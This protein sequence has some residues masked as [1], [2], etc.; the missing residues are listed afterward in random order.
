MLG[1]E[2]GAGLGVLRLE[3]GEPVLQLFGQRVL[4]EAGVVAGSRLAVDGF[5]LRAVG[6]S[7]GEL[8]VQ[9]AQPLGEDV[10]ALVNGHQVVA[11]LEVHQLRFGGFDFG[12]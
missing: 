3:L 11:A 7:L 12:A 8:V 2:L 5:L 6:L 10:L 9:V 4:K 1:T